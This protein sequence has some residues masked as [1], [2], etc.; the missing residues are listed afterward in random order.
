MFF[1]ATYF[2]NVVQKDKKLPSIH[3]FSLTAW[4]N[5]NLKIAVSIFRNIKA[6][7][8][9]FFPEIEVNKINDSKVTYSAII[10]LPLYPHK[11]IELKPLQTFCLQPT[12][13]L[14]L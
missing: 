6:Y 4:L 13:S 2:T 8:C 5:T 14:L 9:H 10:I 1:S 3:K 11:V 7:S 12:T